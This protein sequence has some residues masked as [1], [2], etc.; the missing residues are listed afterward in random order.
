[1]TY[2]EALAY[3]ESLESLGIRP[4]LD[5][6][7]ALLSRLGDPQWAFP[8]VLIGGTNGKGS[9]TAFLA[10]ILRAAG[11][12]RGVY[13]SPHL[14]RFEERIAVDGDQIS[15]DELASLTSEVAAAI[16]AE[17]R[18]GGDLPTYFEATS[19]LAF[20]HF[21]RRRV[22]IA[23]LEVGMGGR[24]DAT[25]VVQPLACAITSVA[26]DHEQWLG[27]TLPEIASQ[28][29]GIIK[30]GVPLVVARQEEPALRVIREE[31]RRLEAPLV[32]T[33]SCQARPSSGRSDHADPPVFSLT[34]PSGR[35]YDHLAIS[36]RGDH[37]VDNASVAVLLA[38]TL[39]A[40]SF[41]GIDVGAI[42]LGLKRAEW[43]ARIEILPGRPDLLLD[44]AHNPA[45]CRT[46][47]A[48]L[49]DHQPGRRKALVFAAM[50][51]KPAAAMLEILCPLAEEV[52]VT[53][54]PVS[55]GESPGRLYELAAA[56]CRRVT[57]EPVIATAL[58]RARAVAGEDGL[59]VASGS[60]Y[61]AG[62]IKKI[63]ARR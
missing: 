52:I 34:T 1:V 41:P 39:A 2:P 55:R 19:A 44:G 3:L 58:D 54:L 22:P 62:E 13:I 53:S 57:I 59:M 5:R 33:E 29:A 30:R 49:R 48:Y 63:L 38:E 8:S 32:E 47:A 7:R 11:V 15:E 28:K 10:S 24:Y 12:R 31:A 45:G 18:A 46:L 51:D 23:V 6:T 50:K 36:L 27:R 21:A 17:R 16:E 42:T 35:R 14:V 37:Q 26:M 40:G 60:L 43:P 9:V 56:R 4:G 61:L 20:L 25:N